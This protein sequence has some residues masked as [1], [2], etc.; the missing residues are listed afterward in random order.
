MRRPLILSSLGWL[1]VGVLIPFALA[2]CR[3][4]PTSAAPAPEA[5]SHLISDKGQSGLEMGPDSVQLAGV[6][7]SVAEVQDLHATV[8][9]TGQVAATDSDAV[10]VTSRLPGKIVDA[11]VAVGTLVRKGQLIARVYS[12]VLTQ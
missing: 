5:N 1:A 9:P 8:Q 2:G 7:T 10:Q 11:L 3:E 4:Q 12:V 6:T